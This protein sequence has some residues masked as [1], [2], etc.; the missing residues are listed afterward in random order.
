MD[1]R[2][3]ERKIAYFSMEIGFQSDIPTYSGGLGILAGDTLK[4]CADLGVPTVAVTLLSEK[5]YFLQR[6]DEQGNQSEVAESWNRDHLEQVPEKVVVSISGRN[7]VV[8]A[9]QYRIKG[10]SGFEV[11]ILFLDTNLPENTEYD[12]TITQHLYQGDDAYRIAQEIV[13]GIAGRKLLVDLG[14]D[15]I[16]TFHLNE[17]HASFLILELLSDS[18][19]YEGDHTYE[20]RYDFE[21]VK[22]KIVFTTHTPVA[23]G[24]DQFDPDLVKS[25]I[26]DN[27]EHELLDRLSFEGKV[28]MTHIALENSYY[29]NGVAKKHAEVSRVMFP[30][31]PIGSITNGVYSPDW[32]CPAMKNVLDKFIPEWFLEPSSL[33]F[34]MLLPD[35]EL[36]EAHMQAKREL[37]QLVNSSTQS[38]LDPDVFTIGFARRATP[39]KRMELLFSD[40]NWLKSLSEKVGKIQI[41]LAGK[42]HPRDIAGKDIIKRVFSLKEQLKGSVDIAYVQNYNIDIAKKLISGVD[43]WLNTPLKPNEA[44]GTSGM[45][46]AHNGVPH[47]SVLDGWWIE[48]W[49]ENVTGWSI[50]TLTSSK[51]EE[52]AHD[53]YMKLEKFI[54]PT[55]YNNRGQWLNIMRQSIA[56]NASYFNTHRMVKDYVLHAYF[57]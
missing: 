5:G 28:N 22:K 3:S 39:Y 53:L 24:H 2:P 38:S 11:P 48:G 10:V 50:G 40:I 57:K 36:W 37:I 23:A 56:L 31:H 26:S 7:V 30:N 51:Q 4:T 12:K 6:L 25:I 9:W 33:R 52:D 16:Q 19:L 44:S 18:M 47:F 13:L 35:D 32:V 1:L 46:A 27:V 8:R 17:G 45:K 20:K 15:N 43:V 54:L 42:A 41:V 14:Y 34:A 21:G 49:L 29:V 55:F